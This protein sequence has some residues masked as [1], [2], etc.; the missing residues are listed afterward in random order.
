M[1]HDGLAGF[2]VESAAFVFHAEHPPQYDG[3]LLELGA[4]TRFDPSRT[5]TPSAQR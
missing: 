2:D 5:A 4:L 1:R 3:D